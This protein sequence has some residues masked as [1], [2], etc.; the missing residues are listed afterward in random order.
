M[1]RWVD[2]Q[3]FDHIANDFKFISQPPS[4]FLEVSVMPTVKKLL[5]LYMSEAP[6]LSIYRRE[7]ND[8]EQQN[9]AWQPR[10]AA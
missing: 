7:N 3:V 6:M 5:P 9:I 8:Y 1:S 10:E 2:R 4:V